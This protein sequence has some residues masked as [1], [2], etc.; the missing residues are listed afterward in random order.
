MYGTTITHPP[1]AYYAYSYLM[2]LYHFQH[3]LMLSSN[4]QRLRNPLLDLTPVPH[5]H[6][7][8]T[9]YSH[10]VV[11]GKDHSRRAIRLARIWK[12]HSTSARRCAIHVSSPLSSSFD[13]GSTIS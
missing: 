13:G 5:V 11:V 7:A 1:F 6:Q 9:A 12:L 3:A 4:M 10:P 2:M 8:I